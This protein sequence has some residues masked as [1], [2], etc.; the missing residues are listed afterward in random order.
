[1]HPLRA[2]LL[3][4]Q[5][6]AS[7]SCDANAA[8]SKCEQVEKIS[9]ASGAAECEYRR[10][11]Y[12]C[13]LQEGCYYNPA[14]NDGFTAVHC[15]ELCAAEPLL[16]TCVE[17][18]NR[19]APQDY[20]LCP[21]LPK[22][23]VTT[24][25]PT[26]EDFLAAPALP[27]T[28]TVW[29]SFRAV[30]SADPA[31]LLPA[32]LPAAI[33]KSL[34]SFFQLDPLAVVV[35]EMSHSKGA[36]TLPGSVAAP[37][38]TQHTSFI[39]LN[40]HIRNVSDI[41]RMQTLV[42]STLVGSFQTE[43]RDGL[44]ALEERL[45]QELDSVFPEAS[46][47]QL[48][49]LQIQA[50]TGLTSDFPALAETTTELTTTTEVPK[51]QLQRWNAWRVRCM[52]G[53]VYR[54]E[55]AE[56]QLWASDCPAPSSAHTDRPHL[57]RG[58]GYRAISSPSFAEFLPENAFDGEPN[59]QRTA[60]LTACVGCSSGET[61]IGLQGEEP[62]RVACVVLW[63]GQ[64]G[65][66]M[67][68][69]T[70]VEASDSLT[71][72]EVQGE[73]DE[74]NEVQTLCVPRRPQD[75]PDLNCGTLADGCGGEVRFGDCPGL[76]QLCESNRCV[77]QGRFE[78]SE[79]RFQG[80]DCGSYEDGCGGSLRFGLCDNST[81]TTCVNHRCKD[82]VFSA[83]HWRLV[84]T[85]QTVGRWMV[86]EVRF[87]TDGLCVIP[88]TTFRRATSSGSQYADFPAV[89][90]FDGEAET[91]W[92]SSCHGCPARK[93]W[94]ALEFQTRVVVRCVRIH[95]SSRTSQ[96][97]ASLSLEYSD[98]GL[99]W[100]ERYKYGSAG[101]TIGEQEQLEADMDAI[102][103]P[104]DVFVEQR[105]AY[106]WRI[107]CL[108]RL[109]VP[110]RIREFDFFDDEECSNSLRGVVSEIFEASPSSWPASNAYDRNEQTVWR[111]QCGECNQAV[112]DTCACTPGQAYIGLRFL[113]RVRPR[114]VVVHQPEEGKGL[115]KT[116]AVQLSDS[117]GL[118]L[119]TWISRKDF[120]NVGSTLVGALPPRASSSLETSGGSTQAHICRGLW[121]LT[122]FRKAWSS[123]RTR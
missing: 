56:L 94:L 92:I 114:C 81:N 10:V 59:L 72:W 47:L 28:F 109:Q 90:A 68:S 16:A 102:F 50:I 111:T 30:E 86:R 48:A 5:V 51:L 15:S 93:A 39:S 78:V 13:M 110:W 100:T 4:L 55:V 89:M 74:L 46:N 99:T 52:E 76:R 12:T 1:M 97:C 26:L 77:C 119:D 53:V 101:N 80:W 105:F 8:L 67:C 37:T 121:M 87:H 91:T 75:F 61:W 107:A 96:Q 112:G 116:L 65:T 24:A 49:R 35:Q 22:D 34:G 103:V 3:L 42:D 73:M 58:A 7:A 19:P 25:P 38:W 66:S 41:Q 2:L 63:Q 40:I 113:R 14:C 71:T 64:S 54:W 84:C 17:T 9:I 43:A 31:S 21:H 33:G 62:F 82:D 115:C 32:L 45:A 122:L 79:P 104:E 120:E 117:L 57:L 123:A 118:Q 95:Q 23:L 98:D 29:I 85:A 20:H 36:L 106:Q 83:A 88:H 18:P 11:F 6:A 69:R 70:V 108:E 44:D 60:W 27:Y